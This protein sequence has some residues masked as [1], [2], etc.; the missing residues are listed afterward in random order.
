M[1]LQLPDSVKAY[2]QAS[3][4]EQL[5][6]LLDAFDENADVVDMNREFNGID[7]IRNWCESE[8][9]KVHV[10]FDITQVMQEDGAYAVIAALDGDF[11]K[12]NLPDPFLL[13]HTFIL[14][15]GKIKKLFISLP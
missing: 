7:A 9:F 5:E 13:K 1:M 6:L 4:T 15:D 3:N 12:T 14:S 2:F 11:D 8:I 10:R